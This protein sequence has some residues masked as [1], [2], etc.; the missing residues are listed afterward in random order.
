[1]PSS[2]D[3]WDAPFAGAD[4]PDERRPEPDVTDD[5]PEPDDDLDVDDDGDA[6]DP[7]IEVEPGDLRDTPFAARRGW[8]L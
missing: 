7:N 3:D 1:M 2:R 4:R 5:E 6:C 8:R